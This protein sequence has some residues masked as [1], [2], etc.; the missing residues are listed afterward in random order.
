MEEN[1]A[2]MLYYR[3]ILKTSHLNQEEF[4]QLTFL[5][6][7][8]RLCL[9]VWNFCLYCWDSLIYRIKLISPNSETRIQD[10]VDEPEVLFGFLKFYFEGGCGWD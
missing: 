9:Y 4:W 8:V 2:R 7:A 6:V 3:K 1:G 5:T 10:D